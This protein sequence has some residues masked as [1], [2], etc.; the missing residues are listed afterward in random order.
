MTGGTIK[1]VRR[2]LPESYRRAVTVGPCHTQRV[3]P[4]SP[5][6]AVTVAF[7]I[8]TGA[9][10]L[11]GCSDDDG[12]DTQQFCAEV[13]ANTAAIVTPALVT[14]D[15]VDETLDTYRE[16]ADLAPISIEEEWRDLL[17]NIETA[18][19]M[20]PDDPESLQRT[21]AVAYATERSAVAVRNWVLAN[22]GVDLG[23]VATI[24]P[25]DPAA[26][27][28]LPVG[29]STSIVTVVPPPTVAPDTTPT[30]LPP[31]VAPTEVPT[32]TTAA[33]G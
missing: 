10:A 33:A 22:C 17:V 18:S 2:R 19:T 15:D 8:V 20:V 31:V 13:A 7:T 1:P 26:T 5:A 16:L 23:P 32:A 30:T 29:I 4:R 21:V 6:V 27:T 11:S 24:A 12:G 14:E 28:T 3:R 9:A 25:Q